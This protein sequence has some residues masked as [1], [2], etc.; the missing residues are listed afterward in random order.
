[1]KNLKVDISG[2]SVDGDNLFM[3]PSC[4][5]FCLHFGVIVPNKCCQSSFQKCAL[6]KQSA[7]SVF[8]KTQTSATSCGTYQ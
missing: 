4:Y 7:T 5:L 2:A 6:R 8:D 3:L 1:M